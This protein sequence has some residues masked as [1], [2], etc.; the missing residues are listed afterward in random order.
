MDPTTAGS[1]GPVQ[2]HYMDDFLLMGTPGTTEC[3]HALATTRATCKDLGI[4]LGDD[5]TEGPVTELSFLG[6]QLN[7]TLMITSLL[8]RQAI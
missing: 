7:S 8:P 1:Q 5:K 6:I 3:R 4:P 2:V